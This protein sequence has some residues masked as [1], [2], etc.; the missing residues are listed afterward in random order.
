MSMIYTDSIDTLK[1]YVGGNDLFEVI[2]DLAID[3]LTDADE[4]YNVKRYFGV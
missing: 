2:Y 1:K 3:K 4:N